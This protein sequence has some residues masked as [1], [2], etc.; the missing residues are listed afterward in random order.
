[1]IPIPAMEKSAAEHDEIIRE[2][3]DEKANIVDDLSSTRDQALEYIRNARQNLTE[4]RSE[5]ST[6]MDQG[7]KLIHNFEAHQS[8]LSRAANDLL[9]IYRNA[10]MRARGT[11]APA[12]FNVSYMLPKVSSATA[13]HI[14]NEKLL[15]SSIDKTDEALQKAISQVNTQFEEAVS[16][17]HQVGEFTT[18][19][20]RAA[21]PTTA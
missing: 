7:E 9:S 16:E 3:T 19:G 21:Q 20:D 1:M 11:Q 2:Y 6:I 5:F 8:Y 13:P 10:N 17:F 15:G 4:R 18:G 12:H 14:G